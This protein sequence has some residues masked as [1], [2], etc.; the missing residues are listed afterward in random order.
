MKIKFLIATLITLTSILCACIYLILNLGME[1]DGL[2]QVVSG[3]RE[4]LAV[5]LDYSAV[6]TNC[7]VMIEDVGVFL[8]ARHPSVGLR[9]GANSVAGLSF[10]LSFKEGRPAEL[11]IVEVGKTILCKK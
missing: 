10:K 5:L 4:T 7:N 1:N 9:R 3:Q 6:A 11:E 2:R 8:N